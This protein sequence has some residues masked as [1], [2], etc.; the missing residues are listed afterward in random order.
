MASQEVA[1]EVECWEEWDRAWV[2]EGQVAGIR[3]EAG[4]AKS[5]LYLLPAFP[6]PF[7]LS[8]FVV[9]PLLHFLSFPLKHF[10][11]SLL[12]PVLLTLLSCKSH[13]FFPPVYH[14]PCVQETVNIAGLRLLSLKGLLTRLALGWH[15]ETLPLN[16]S[17][18][19]S[20]SR[21]SGALNTCFL[22]GIWTFGSCGRS[23]CLSDKL[24]IKI[25]DAVSEAG[26]TGLNTMPVS[27]HLIARGSRNTFLPGAR[28]RTE[29]IWAWIPPDPS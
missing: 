20:L 18:S 28:A 29:E 19:D 25:L 7:F 1:C 15:L 14:S 17:L 13:P 4:S 21:P 23:L 24:P 27:L 10:V 5:L 12:S 22:L 9:L 3:G 6:L 11:L 16:H 8:S 26:L 2:L